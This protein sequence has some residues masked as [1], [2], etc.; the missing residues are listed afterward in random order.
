MG[1]RNK[2]E[3]L[4]CIKLHLLPDGRVKLSSTCG[5]KFDSQYLAMPDARAP[6]Q[7]LVLLGELRERLAGGVNP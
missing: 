6:A 1:K 5:G 3:S 7:V 2:P 4:A